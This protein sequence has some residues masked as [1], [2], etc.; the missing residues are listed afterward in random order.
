MCSRTQADSVTPREA[1]LG[2]RVAWKP[3]Q[4][5]N[6]QRNGAC[7]LQKRG[8][9]AGAWHEQYT[10]RD[11]CQELDLYQGLSRQHPYRVGRILLE[12]EELKSREGNDW[13]K[14]T[15]SRGKGQTGLFPLPCSVCGILAPGEV[16]GSGVGRGRW[17]GRAPRSWLEHILPLSSLPQ[18]Q[19]HSVAGKGVHSARQTTWGRCW[20][21]HFLAGRLGAHGLIS[22]SSVFW[23]W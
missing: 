7:G 11:L 3:C 4:V 14:F 19:Q 5:A 23:N 15:H 8:R 2:W 6:H 17:W 9:G 22:S 16:V 12:D 21:C 13:F 1:G 18:R 20:L 10:G